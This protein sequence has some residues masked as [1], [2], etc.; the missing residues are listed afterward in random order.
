MYCQLMSTLNFQ[1]AMLMKSAVTLFYSLTHDVAVSST[2]PRL[3][4]QPS[5]SYPPRRKEDMFMRCSRE[6]EANRY[7]SGLLSESLILIMKQQKYVKCL[8]LLSPLLR[9]SELHSEISKPGVHL[10]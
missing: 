4:I 5:S 10:T 3:R 7:T 1:D 8:T 9:I 2:S 6:Q